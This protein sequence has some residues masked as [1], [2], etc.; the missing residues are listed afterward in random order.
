MSDEKLVMMVSSLADSLT[1]LVAIKE[2]SLYNV[3]ELV[4][5]VN[6]LAV[7]ISVGSPVD[8]SSDIPF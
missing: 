7:R 1:R 3:D 8:Q 6:R 4:K 5:V 2:I